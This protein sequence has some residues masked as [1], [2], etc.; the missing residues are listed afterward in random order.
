MDFP[1]KEGSHL[2][3][4]QKVFVTYFGAEGSWFVELGIQQ[5]ASFLAIRDSDAWFFL[6]QDES[7]VVNPPN[8]HPS[9]ASGANLSLHSF[10][11]K[12]QR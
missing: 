8:S 10:Q 5:L 7:R 4:I 6:L 1:E 2:K 9:G 12:L 11:P 3:Q